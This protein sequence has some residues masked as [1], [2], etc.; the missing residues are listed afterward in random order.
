MPFNQA[1]AIAS[2]G[3]ASLQNDFVVKNAFADGAAK[4]PLPGDPTDIVEATMGEIHLYHRVTGYPAKTYKEGVFFLLSAQKSII[5]CSSNTQSLFGSD[6]AALIGKS[7]S[8]LFEQASKVETAL[9]AEDFWAVSPVV[10]KSKGG[11]VNIVLQRGPNGIMVDVEPVGDE[12]DI[13]SKIA[14]VKAAVGKFD[15]CNTEQELCDQI[16]SLMNE[17]WGWDRSFVWKFNED[18]TSYVPAEICSAN[19]KNPVKG[20]SLYE[21]DLPPNAKHNYLHRTY[22]RVLV[23]VADEGV[24]LVVDA[25]RGLEPEEISLMKSNLRRLHQC[26]VD[27]LGAWTIRA[28][29]MFPVVVQRR[30]YGLITFAHNSALPMPPFQTRLAMEWLTQAFALK[31]AKVLDAELSKR[32]EAAS[33]FVAAV[34]KQAGAAGDEGG[35]LKAFLDFSAEVCNAVP[36]VSSVAVYHKGKIHAAGSV[37]AGDAQKVVGKMLEV[38]HPNTKQPTAFRALSELS[39]E[40]QGI[41]GAAGVVLVPLMSDSVLLLFRPD[42]NETLTMAGVSSVTY[43]RKTGRMTARRD[44]GTPTPVKQAGLCSM[45]SASDMAAARALS[46]TLGAILAGSPM[47]TESGVGMD[48]A[49]TMEVGDKLQKLEARVSTLV[50]ELKAK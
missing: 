15:A 47:P 5:A 33:A 21:H 12:A 35:K 7:F 31:L 6:G 22:A 43:N 41:A 18:D 25:A 2:N 1:A 8:S 17:M 49:A 14:A 11:A 37:A 27:Q 36:G 44:A 28:N 19:V 30:L 16:V 23:D 26:A 29:A 45:W 34:A 39:P 46:A 3:G 42:A 10:V 50:A 9:A 48:A 38:W 40:L 20:M 4:A 24:E 13:E 32:Q